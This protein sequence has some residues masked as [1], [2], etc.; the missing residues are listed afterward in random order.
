MAASD[1]ARPRDAADVVL[2]RLRD[3]D[4]AASV[5]TILDHADLLAT[6]VSGLSDFVARSDTIIESVSAGVAE[7]AS[8]NRGSGNGTPLPSAEDLKALLNEFSAATPA[9]R[10]VLRS[11][12]VSDST[13]E[14]LSLA[15]ASVAEGS[16]A[17]RTK[18]TTVTG[19]R[20][21]LALAKDREV[22]RGLGLMA[23][24]ARAMGRR[25]DAPQSPASRAKE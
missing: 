16:E 9:I 14:F 19:I 1:V 21:V 6:L 22:G 15:S 8:A 3:P 10:K 7:L 18:R 20:G 12:M 11:D 13:I 4:V 2:E 17:A 25:L 23:E 5:L 24:I